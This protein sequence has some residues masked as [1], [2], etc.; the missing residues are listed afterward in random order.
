MGCG[1]GHDDKVSRQT[2]PW[3]DQH[4]LLIRIP[5]HWTDHWALIHCGAYHKFR[6]KKPWSWTCPDV[7]LEWL[8]LIIRHSTL[9][10]W[11]VFQLKCSRNQSN[12]ASRPQNR[13]NSF[14]F[15]AEYLHHAIFHQTLHLRGYWHMHRFLPVLSRPG[16]LRW[17]WV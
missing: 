13:Q 16:V 14:A 17:N 15:S 9:R 2:L 6:Q 1:F 11:P 5:G 7:A 3:T 8:P 4:F 10:K 12:T